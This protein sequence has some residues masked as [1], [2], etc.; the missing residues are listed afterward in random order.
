MFVVELKA[1]TQFDNHCKYFAFWKVLLKMNHWILTRSYNR[2]QSGL[3]EYAEYIIERNKVADYMQVVDPRTEEEK[4]NASD[5]QEIGLQQAKDKN[6]ASGKCC[7][8]LVAS[9]QYSRY[10]GIV[11]K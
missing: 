7:D 2:L 8:L 5:L 10:C 1:N 9:W 6:Y 4:I 11:R 3:R